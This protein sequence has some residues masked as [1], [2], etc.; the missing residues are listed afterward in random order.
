MTSLPTNYKTL[1]HSTNH[2]IA[3]EWLES[4]GTNNFIELL[5]WTPDDVTTNMAAICKLMSYIHD[6]LVESLLNI[7]LDAASHGLLIDHL[8]ESHEPVNI[9]IICCLFRNIITT[10]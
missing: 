3:R 6:R 4:R 8:L 10:Y 5:Q 1:F 7:P 2:S 9:P